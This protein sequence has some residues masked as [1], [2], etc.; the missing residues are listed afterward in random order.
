MQILA[1]RK[2]SQRRRLHI[3]PWPSHLSLFFSFFLCPFPWYPR[4]FVDSHI[5]TFCICHILVFLSYTFFSLYDC[6]LAHRS[7]LAFISSWETLYAGA[8]LCV[9]SASYFARPFVTIIEGG[10]S[11]RFISWHLIYLHLFLLVC[12]LARAH[13]EHLVFSPVLSGI[14]RMYIKYH[15]MAPGW[16]C[17]SARLL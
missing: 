17:F 8:A 12:I 7:V 9:F 16:Q 15:I 11:F 1:G 13:C 3:S 10:V 14:S 6:T 2:V 5:T 4:F